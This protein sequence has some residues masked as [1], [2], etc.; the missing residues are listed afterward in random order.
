MLRLDNA[1]LC[2]RI[3]RG[4]VGKHAKGRE[5]VG[6][7]LGAGTLLCIKS[8]ESRDSA[9]SP[10]SDRL[11]TQGGKVIPKVAYEAQLQAGLS[12]AS[13]G[14]RGVGRIIHQCA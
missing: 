1:T 11:L 12:C 8:S 14:Y 2:D 6:G 9:G 7:C 13:T 3:R 4:R 5:T 10:D